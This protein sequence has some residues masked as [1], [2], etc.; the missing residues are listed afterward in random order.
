[1]ARVIAIITLVLVVVMG[2]VT[3]VGCNGT[4][5]N[6][7]VPNGE[8]NGEVPNGG[9]PNGELP[10]GGEPN[11]EELAN[12]DLSGL[13]LIVDCDENT[14]GEDPVVGDTALDF[15]FQDSVGT[16]FS[17]SDFRGRVVI[18]NF[19]GTKCGF[20]T[21]EL[22]YI[23]R[24]YD[25]WPTTE[26]VVLLTIARGDEPAEVVTFMQEKEVFFPVL[27]DRSIIVSGEYK[28]TGIPRTFFIDSEGVIRVIH[29]GYF[30]SYA[31]IE[32]DLNPLLGLPVGELDL[33]GL[34]MIV[35]CDQNTSGEE[36][37]V[38]DMALDFRFQDA[39]GQ[40][41]SLSDS[42]G[43][44][45]V[46]NFWSTTCSAC[47]SELPYIQQLYDEW[48]TTEEVVLLTIARG[49]RPAEVATCMQEEDVSFPV[50][51]DKDYIV[52]DEYEANSIP[53]TFF[54]DSQGVIQVIKLGPFHSYEDI[55]EIL[56][57][58]LSQ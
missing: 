39:E 7:Y 40:I 26:E 44:L 38:G 50:A 27:V 9:E 21:A 42:R 18:L 28:V 6:G 36:P 8:D 4:E 32:A 10:N 11:G 57:Q 13:G 15:R 25:E 47:I 56:N 55:E 54:I 34:D 17:L 49:D 5:S 48:S 14:S 31:D 33:S 51:V 1:M 41:S 2:L 23:Q 37:E 12:P 45:V 46:L 20:C 22:P 52:S 58:L 35:D 3:A 43:K 53:R 24:L 16:T 19:W 29:R 30:H